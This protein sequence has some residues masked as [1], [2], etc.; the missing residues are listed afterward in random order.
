ME[1]TKLQ[2]L[3]HQYDVN[4]VEQGFNK[5]LTK[6]LPKDITYCRTIENQMRAHL[7]T[8]G[9]QLIGYRQVYKCCVC[10]YRN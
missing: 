9:L 2:Q 10:A 7:P 1:D 8:V 5:L 4:S 6:F 3:F